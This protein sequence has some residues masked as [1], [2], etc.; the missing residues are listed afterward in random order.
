MIMK[1]RE[2]MISWDDLSVFL[3]A[4]EVAVTNYNQDE[5]RSLLMQIVPEFKPQCAI[6]DLLYKKY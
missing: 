6:S 1:A 3:N 4:L 5:L 2:E